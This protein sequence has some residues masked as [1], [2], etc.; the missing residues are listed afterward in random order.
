MFCLAGHSLFRCLFFNIS[1]PVGVK[2]L[3]DSRNL[4][5]RLDSQL[6]SLDG[7]WPL[8]RTLCKA[9]GLR[10]GVEESTPISGEKDRRLSGGDGALAIT[11]G[12]IALSA[13]KLSLLIF[14][15]KN[16][17]SSHSILLTPPSGSI[18]LTPAGKYHTRLTK[19]KIK[20]VLKTKPKL[21]ITINNNY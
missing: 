14:W 15:T 21:I 9:R 8:R 6:V 16:D 2:G 4:L 11:K 10:N 12:G 7:D 1:M 3:T 19:T 18:A 17:S 20:T 5:E 13:S